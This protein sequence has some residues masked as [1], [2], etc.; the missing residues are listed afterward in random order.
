[1]ADPYQNKISKSTA[2]GG[3]NTKH[4]ALR[5]LKSRVA[6]LSHNGKNK[7]KSQGVAKTVAGTGGFVL[8]K[9]DKHKKGKTK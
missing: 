3:V 1:M 4:I 5:R 7:P 6:A 2:R 9:C 8:T